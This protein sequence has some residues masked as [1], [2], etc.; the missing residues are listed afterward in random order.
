MKALIRT[1]NNKKYKIDFGVEKPS[2]SGTW[3]SLIEDMDPSKD[4]SIFFSSKTQ[5]IMLC[6]MLSKMKLKGTMRK[7]KKG[8][9]VWRV[10]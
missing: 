8:Y 10:K 5:A 1:V 7:V 6:S 3:K 9:R 4:A 2:T